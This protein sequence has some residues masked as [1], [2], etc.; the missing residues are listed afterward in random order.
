MQGAV[1]IPQ[2]ATRLLETA[3]KYVVQAQA[4]FGQQAKFDNPKQTAITLDRFA[5]DLDPHEKQTYS[6][7]LALRQTSIFRVLPHSV[8]HRPLNTLQNRLSRTIAQRN[9]F[10]LEFAI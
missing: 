8:Y 6:K 4:E 5:Y 10:P 9:S 3:E 7:F 1:M 2:E